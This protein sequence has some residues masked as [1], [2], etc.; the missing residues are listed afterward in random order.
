MVKKI[1]AMFLFIVIF[2]SPVFAVTRHEGVIDENAQALAIRK[3]KVNSLVTP[4]IYSDTLT[5]LDIL[6][7]DADT[8]DIDELR[9]ALKTMAHNQ[10]LL[11]QLIQEL[12]E[13]NF[14]IN[15]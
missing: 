12:I 8:M 7:A 10:K 6:I 14:E 2:S 13:H 15:E 1:T 5:V 9:S 3:E 11:F 4:K